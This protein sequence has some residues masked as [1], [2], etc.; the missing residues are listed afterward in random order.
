[1]KKFLF[2]LMGVFVFMGLFGCGKK[3]YKLNFD[4]YGFESKKTSY[5]EGETVTVYYDLIA[6]D[7]DYTFTCDSDVK[8]ERDYDGQHGYVFVFTM[9]DH[10]VTLHVESR[11]SMEYDPDAHLPETPPDLKDEIDPENMYF[12][13]YEKTVSAEDKSGHEEYVLY[14]RNEGV[15]MILAVYTK[16]GEAQEEMKCCLV[17]EDT[18][19]SCMNIVRGYNMAGW[20]KETSLEG[21]YIVVKFKDSNGNPV[22]VSSDEMPKDGYGAFD[23]ISEILWR[24]WEQYGE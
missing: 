9:P 15:G 22:R 14:E 10:D 13:Y 20:E 7:T 17:P 18:W 19:D 11:N 2:V 23:S 5:E 4:G 8:M 16:E 24:A 3:M 1:M 6:T 21:K 12:D